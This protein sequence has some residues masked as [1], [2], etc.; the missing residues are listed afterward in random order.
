M[1][2]R[3]KPKEELPSFPQEAVKFTG[4][5]TLAFPFSVLIIAFQIP[6]HI[7]MPGG[8]PAASEKD[9]RQGR[10]PSR[11]RLVDGR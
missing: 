8:E 7:G 5:L 1:K 11:C 9:C 6:K 4:S 10:T 2:F 3:D